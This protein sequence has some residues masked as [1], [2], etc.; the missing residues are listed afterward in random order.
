M[1]LPDFVPALTARPPPDFWPP[2]MTRNL[3]GRYSLADCLGY[4]SQCKKLSELKPLLKVSTCISY[5]YYK[6]VT[7]MQKSGV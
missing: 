7:V 5:Q 3:P 1:P 6:K 4:W 2:R